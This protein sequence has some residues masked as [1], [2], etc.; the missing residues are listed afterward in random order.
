MRERIWI[1]TLIAFLLP[2]V[3]LGCGPAGP[4][5]EIAFSHILNEQSEWHVGAVRWKKLVEERLG[6]ALSVRLVTNAS[7]SNNNQRTELEMVQAGT[8]GGSWE[9]SI[10]LSIIDARW[11]VWSMPWLFDSY[12]E[13]EKICESSL[14]RD[15]LASLEEKGLVGLA[16]G[17]NGF[18]RLTNSRRAV[19]GVDDM[20]QLKIRVPSLQM[21][22]SLFQK[23]G[24]DPSQMNFGDLV[25]ALREGT[26]DGQENP[27]HVIHA[28]GLYDLQHYLTLWEYSFDPL[29]FCLSKRVWDRLDAKTQTVLREAAQEA[30]QVQ[31]DTVVQQEE[32]HL[33]FLKE[34]GMQVAVLSPAAIQ[35]FKE[36]SQPVYAEFRETIGGDILVPF[37][38]AARP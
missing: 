37:V 5:K 32:N 35:Q 24:A 3:A 17:F 11:T 33:Q 12:E 20:K 21:Y 2:A 22:I 4:P 28:T 6:D 19:V 16:Y 15:M 10:L 31:R 14:G 36:L 18:R 34:H 8:L 13:A 38:D 29:I 23:W 1:K 30:A 25:V 7:L 27:L 26:M 9:S